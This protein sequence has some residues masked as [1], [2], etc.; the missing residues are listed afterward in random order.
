MKNTWLQNV[1]KMFLATG[2]FL[3]LFACASQDEMRIDYEIDPEEVINEIKA[4][5]QFEEV[6][7]KGV[8]ITSNKG[9]TN[10]LMIDLVNG[11]SLEERGDELKELGADVLSIVTDAMV[12][13]NDFEEF[14]VGFT[15]RRGLGIISG[16]FSRSFE[17]KLEDLD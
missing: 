16:S 14:R 6:E 10:L 12:N 17:Y 1:V 3:I 11:E 9:A 7:I 2:T 5:K 4:L 8:T 15:Q 13:E